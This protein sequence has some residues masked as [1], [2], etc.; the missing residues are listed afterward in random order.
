M[1]E[2]CLNFNVMFDILLLESNFIS[3]EKYSNIVWRSGEETKCLVTVSH[4]HFIFSTCR[5][6]NIHSVNIYDYQ[7]GT[8]ATVK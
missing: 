6:S 7:L 5:T 1:E 3:M 4:K 8:W 2:K